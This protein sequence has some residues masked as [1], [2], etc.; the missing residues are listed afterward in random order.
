MIARSRLVAIAVTT[1]LVAG[2]AC[3]AHN[4]EVAG[5]PAPS[6]GTRGFTLVA[7]GDVLPH[8]P[9]IDRA[10]F[11]AG[12]KGY[13]F[14]P[15]F[16]GVRPVV[17]RADLALCHME[18]VYGED[19]E[20]TGYP[21]FK[22][23]PEVARGIASAGY[24]GCSTASNHSLDDGAAGILRTLNAL[25]QAKVRHAGTA[26]TSG[27]ARSVTVMRAG[28]AKVAHL[29]Y[30]YGVNDFPLPPGQPWAVNLIDREKIVA[31]AR[32]ARKGGADVVVVS[33]H[34]GTEWQDA[35]DEEQLNLA[36]ELTAARTGD[37]PDIDL[38]LGT[39]AHVPQAYEKVNG[40]WVVYGMGD[41]VAGA[42]YNS[43][44]VQDPRGNQSTLARFRFD[45]PARAGGRWEVSKAEFVPQLFDIDAGRVLNLNQAI[46]KGAEL[47]GVRDRIREVVL[48][49][50]AGDD[51]LSMGE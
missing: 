9:I 45:P 49:R 32:A 2:A 11:D 31:D 41:Q 35:P 26:R 46:A 40:T 47:S 15:M 5:R 30:T 38:I 33:M 4:R 18:T 50:G 37:R 21:L 14:R 36:R 24:D 48:S 20:Y 44:G 1:V 7:S 6:A 29:A 22:S 13:D 10:R 39:H 25:D 28:R 23:P 3:Q 16:A 34:W 51:G 8:T 19:G 17:S 12:G 42:M 43:Q 27:E